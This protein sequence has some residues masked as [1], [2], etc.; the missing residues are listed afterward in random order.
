MCEHPTMLL[1]FFCRFVSRLNVRVLL[2]FKVKPRRRRHETGP[3]TD[4]NAFRLCIDASDRD[5]LLDESKWSKHIVISDWYH[6]N[7]TANRQQVAG[8]AVD[9]AAG[10]S[11]DFPDQGPP[12]VDISAQAHDT[13]VLYHRDDN[14]VN[15]HMLSGD[16]HGC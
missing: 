1:I 8:G 11:R 9:G 3:I 16:T 6:V 14:V 15:M 4:R 7:P 2:C 5:R 12:V 10:V 13:T